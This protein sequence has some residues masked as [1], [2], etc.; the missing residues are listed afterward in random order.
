MNSPIIKN[1]LPEYHLCSIDELFEYLQTTQKGLSAEDVVLRLKKFGTNELRVK[2][3]V[4]EIIKFFKQFKNFF[5]LLL[6]AGSALALFAE[7]LDPGQ[8]NLY[9]AIALFGVTVLNAIFTYIQ[10]YQSEKIMESFEYSS[11]STSLRQLC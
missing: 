11:F 8:G 4:P 3:E 10:Q 5:A 1:K 9:I 7:Q 6:I 2:Q